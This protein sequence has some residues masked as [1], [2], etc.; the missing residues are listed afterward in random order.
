MATDDD[1]NSLN[2]NN[3]SSFD[4]HV[5]HGYSSS[6]VDQNEPPNTCGAQHKTMKIHPDTQVE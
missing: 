2:I 5:Q 4:K 1:D 6:T 3:N